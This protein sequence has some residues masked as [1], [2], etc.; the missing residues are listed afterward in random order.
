MEARFTI[1]KKFVVNGKEYASLAELPQAVRDAYERAKVSG[2][3]S[4]G[5]GRITINGREFENADA[6]PPDLRPLYDDAMR[7]IEGAG[8]MPAG[9]AAATR[10]LP[11]SV[12]ALASDA[13]E[14]SS[15]LPRWLIVAIALLAAAGVYTFFAR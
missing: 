9:S 4:T 10:L 6:I 3:P 11:G 5:S 15:L 12:P 13:G 14:T 1:R 2:G 7:E 8:A